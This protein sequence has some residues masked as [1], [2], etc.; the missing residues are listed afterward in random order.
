MDQGIFIT[1]F[2]S[3]LWVERYSQ[4]GEFK[5]T[6]RVSAGL[7]DRLPIGSFISHTDTTQI[8]IVENHVITEE[9]GKDALIEVTGRSFETVLEQY[10]VG[11]S[12][13]DGNPGSYSSGQQDYQLTADYPFI[14]AVRLIRQH[15]GFRSAGLV[16]G[17][18]DPGNELR[19]VSPYTQLA[20]TGP[21][22]ARS[23]K[24]G[25]VH[26]RVREILAGDPAI[27]FD[28]GIKSV[29][30]GPWSPLPSS[31]YDPVD[32][33]VDF[34]AGST[35]LLVHTGLDRSNTV[36]FSSD[37]GEITKANYIWSNKGLKN[38]ALI[39]GRWVTCVVVPTAMGKDRR[40]LLVDASDLDQYLSD[41]PVGATLT[42]IVDA[43]RKR[44]AD[45]LRSYKSTALSEVEIEPNTTGAVYRRD[46]DIGDIITVHGS[47]GTVS[48][49]R[50]SE[51]V[52]VEDE[53]GNTKYPTL[54]E[55]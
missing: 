49:K 32:G 4:P 36:S 51:Y 52:E 5:L 6:G 15:I 16:G 53:R 3:K 45:A 13:Y 54:T 23:L 41:P 9:R 18:I 40:M 38:Y 14:Q 48:K 25:T 20:G 19:Y 22:T 47:Y 31:I 12:M 27:G 39:Q 24:R 44:G 30:P 50:V 11:S 1:E 35:T 8:M 21:I 28:L 17:P 55:L 2:L 7:R 26:E 34:E 37:T 29:R 10:V 43:M 33:F 42:A 46:F